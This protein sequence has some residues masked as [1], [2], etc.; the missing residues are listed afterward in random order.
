MTDTTTRAHKSKWR[1]LLCVRCCVVATTML[2][3]NTSST[4]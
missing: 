2:R 1:C 3:D 4:H